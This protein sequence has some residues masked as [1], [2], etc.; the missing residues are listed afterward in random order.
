[1]AGFSRM[2]DK[3]SAQLG[4]PEAAGGA[5][6]NVT[7]NPETDT[8]PSESDGDA[9]ICTKCG[10]DMVLRKAAKGK[11]AGQEFWGCSNYPKCK[12]IVPV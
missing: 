10:G 9:P 12:T 8:L 4:E 5:D 3:I 7:V 11:N 2:G 1:M 6:V